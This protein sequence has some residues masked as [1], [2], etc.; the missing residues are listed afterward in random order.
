M[1]RHI[2]VNWAKTWR[3]VEMKKL[4]WWFSRSTYEEEFQDQLKTIGS[5][6][7]QAPKNVLCYPPQH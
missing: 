3:G 4:L 6:S 1:V 2:E 5:T 7:E